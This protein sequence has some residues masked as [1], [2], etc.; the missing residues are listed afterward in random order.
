MTVTWHVV[1]KLLMISR[2]SKVTIKIKC[3]P[4]SN[5]LPSIWFFPGLCLEVDLILMMT[6]HFCS[7]RQCWAPVS[8]IQMAITATVSCFLTSSFS[9][10][11]AFKLILHIP[12]NAIGMISIFFL[13]NCEKIESDFSEAPTQKGMDRYLDSL[14]DPVLSDGNG[15]SF[16][17]SLPQFSKSS[18]VFNKCKCNRCLT[19]PL[20]HYDHLPTVLL[21]LAWTLQE[22]WRCAVVSG[23]K[24]LSFESCR[25]W[26]EPPWIK[27]VGSAN[28]TGAQL[29]WDLANLEVNPLSSS[30]CSSNN[31]IFALKM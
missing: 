19:T 14:F 28:P 15:V 16:S 10:W 1:E 21:V 12:Y 22:S 29:D 27:F 30:S 18:W 3:N 9:F 13:K 5:T 11:L 26:G 31:V 7:L 23:T 8:Q 2:M 6:T 20:W 4:E 24:T 17:C 25:L